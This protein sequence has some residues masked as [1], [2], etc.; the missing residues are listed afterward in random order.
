MSSTGNG[1]D[2]RGRAG[3][4]S[5]W[6]TSSRAIDAYQAGDTADLGDGETITVQPNGDYR[7]GGQ[8]GTALGPGATH[9]RDRRKP[10]GIHARQL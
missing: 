9:L 4:I 7:L 1:R 6:G 8:R 3:Q 10:A 5:V 2:R